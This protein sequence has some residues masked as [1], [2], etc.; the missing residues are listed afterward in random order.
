VTHVALV[1]LGRTGLYTLAGVMGV[2]DVDPFILSL[3]Q[4]AGSLTPVALAGGAITIAA[5]GNN[6]MK[7]IYAYGF[8]D[9]RTGIQGLALLVGLAVLGLIP[10]TF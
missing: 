8:A 2:S 4:S 3:A 5:A 7:G 9:H 10:L 6:V 1:H